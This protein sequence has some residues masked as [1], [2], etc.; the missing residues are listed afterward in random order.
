MLLTL[1]ELPAELNGTL[2]YGWDGGVDVFAVRANAWST[3]LDAVADPS[4][5]EPNWESA[6][7]SCGDAVEVSG[8]EL[9]PHPSDPYVRRVVF[10]ERRPLPDSSFVKCTLV[11]GGAEGGEPTTSAVAFDTLDLP[12]HL[13]PFAQPD[14][15]LV[16]L[17]RDLF[18]VHTQVESDGS[19]WVGSV[20]VP[21]GNGVPDLAE[22]LY[23]LGLGA[24][25]APSASAVV[26]ERLLQV[27]RAHAHRIFGLLDDGTAGPEG[28]PLVLHFEGEA[29]APDPASFD[30]Q[31]FSMIALGGDGD[32]DDQAEGTVGRALID[33]NNQEVEDDTVFGLG[34]FPTAIARQVLAQPLGVMLLGGLVPA[35]GGTPIGLHPRD[36]ELLKPGFDRAKEPDPDV[37]ERFELL[38]LTVDLL[39][40]ALASTLCHEMGHSLGL[41][42]FGPPP[43][44]LFAEVAGLQFTDHDVP[45]A[46]IDT[47]GLNVMQTG[48]VTN[49]LE[50][51]SQEPVFNP[52]NLAYLRRRIVV[53][54]P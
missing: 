42:P 35:A 18:E 17:S 28:V 31:S 7:L 13:D 26:Q 6:T 50:A 37:V 40:L 14:P 44:G 16:V 4:A 2:P 33:W 34:V 9:M 20:H 30:G 12:P 25:E 29:G 11:V 48:K 41:V 1:N 32:L 49:W 15:W 22:G 23:L 54:T 10:D 52:L 21:G 39:G 53:G 46:H 36:A 3:T 45:G 51:L 24:A 43:E 47:K 38:S 19:I 27:V 5:G 8:A